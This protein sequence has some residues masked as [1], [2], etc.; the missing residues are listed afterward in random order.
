MY[1]NFALFVFCQITWCVLSQ[2]SWHALAKAYL[3]EIKKLVCLK[4]SLIESCYPQYCCVR[5]VSSPNLKFLVFCRF[6]NGMVVNDP[7]QTLYQ[8]MSGRQP[9]AVKE[10]A[11]LVSFQPISFRLARLPSKTHE[12]GLSSNRLMPFCIRV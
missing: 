9:I 4:P 6:A 8:L 5:S 1:H 11:D 7:L 10:C 12:V 3:H 2:T